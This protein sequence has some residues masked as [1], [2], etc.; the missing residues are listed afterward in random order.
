M[1][2]VLTIAGR[3]CV[4]L[5]LTPT[6]WGALAVF[7][8][9][10]GIITGI[11]VLVPGS[12]AE[13]R[14][15]AAAAGWAMLLAAPALSLRPTTEERRTGFW[16][17]L[18]TS[19]AS[20]GSI[21]VG[22]YL[23][24]LLAL[25]LL[26]LVGLGGPFAVLETLTRPDLGAALCATLGVLLVGSVY[27]ASG[28]FFGSIST[29]ASVGYLST[30]FSWV[31]LLIAIRSI[32][33][34]LSSAQADILFAAD[35]VRRLE[36]FLDGELDSSNILY[37]IFVTAGFLIAAGAV[38]ATEAERGSHR[39]ALGVRL[40]TV[41]GVMVAFALVIGLAAIAHASPLRFSRDA[42]KSRAWV[43]DDH[44]L[45]MA[46]ALPQGW[47]IT[48]I[49]PIGGLDSAVADQL[50]EVLSAFDHAR[51][52]ARSPHRRIDPTTPTGA[53]EY[54]LW[55][56][57]LVG[58]RRGSPREL[59]DAVESGIKEL[60]I[61]GEY[62]SK[63][64]AQIELVLGQLPAESQDRMQLE[65]TVGAMKAVASGA[66]VLVQTIR[67][68]Q[69]GRPDRALSD[70]SESAE[71][72]A[73][74]NRDWA[75]Q[76]GSFSNWLAGRGADA[77]AALP[78]QEYAHNA[79][80]ELGVRA[81]ALLRTVDALDAIP[82]DPLQEISVGLARGGGVAIESPSGV[83]FLEDS[84]LAVSSADQ[85]STVRFDRRF[86]MEQLITGAIGSIRDDQIP[87]VIVVH[88][89]DRTMLVPATDGFDS[90]AIADALRASRIGVRE[91]RV[92]AEPRPIT[93]DRSVWLIIPPRTVAVERDARERVLLE[94]VGE[95][96]ADGQPLFFSLGPS[97]RPLAGR[98]DPWSEIA[99]TL[100]AR[101][102]SDA[103]IVDDIPIAQGRTQRRT[104]MEVEVIPSD[105]ALARALVDQKI[106]FSVAIPIDRV[107]G[108]S[109]M[110]SDAILATR[111]G[112]SRAI[113]R[114]WRRRSPDA[115]STK[116]VTEST[117]VAVATTR[118]APSGQ[119]IRTIIVGSPS[120]M[121]TS[122]VD[123]ARSYGGG[124]EALQHPGNREFA[125]NG[126]LWLAGLDQRMGSGG[127]GRETPRIGA[128]TLRRRMEYTAGLGLGVPAIALLIGV[129]I[130]FW[131]SR[132]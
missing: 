124:R 67:A 78:L 41:L 57:E 31:V 115:R 39:G 33:P 80:P 50:A 11:A 105:R 99:M 37:F 84:A 119:T 86:R 68:M 56:D 126:V 79:R 52:D 9:A 116:V 100:G 58:R 48:W 71:V 54:A 113:E 63:E 123:A 34:V 88:A 129:V 26:C 45:H 49:A 92:A 118:R 114:D 36:G 76:L 77:Q 101:A 132:G 82:T 122:V 15:V 91:W 3:E 14:T 97:L 74:N 51:S 42:T 85:A 94:A 104:K 59:H 121:V 38:Q 1:R 55:L 46:G 62:A 130:R 12:P 64:C 98:S 90:C 110:S 18:A 103:V 66:P 83:A 131:R 106:G 28:A 13:L 25:A 21:V 8:F 107:T 30:F 69:V 6:V 24:G 70:H 125:V 81:R 102:L 23:A 112:P 53:A 87:E 20:V 16:E 44:A 29:S 2:D 73:G 43:L 128:L 109:G 17:V 95:L 75:M 60:E 93:G 5:F 27:L 19:P 89:E 61:L 65:Q 35:P 108:V 127:S 96:V 22:R 47:R 40:R 7:A 32:A 120:W 10:T 117:S 72:V 111:E 4:A